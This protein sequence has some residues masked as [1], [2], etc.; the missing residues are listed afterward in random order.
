MCNKHGFLLVSKVSFAP[1][2]ALRTNHSTNSN[3]VIY[4]I[5]PF[6]FNW[7]ARDAINDSTMADDEILISTITFSKAPRSALNHLYSSNPEYHFLF[8][9]TK[10]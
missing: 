10:G 6:L 8:R 2:F 5:P 7:T 9:E 3:A 1:N 4:A